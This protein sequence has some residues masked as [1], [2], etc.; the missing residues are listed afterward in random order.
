VK[1]SWDERKRSC[2]T[3]Q[4]CARHADWVS[5]DGDSLSCAEGE[6]SEEGNG[7]AFGETKDIKKDISYHYEVEADNV[8]DGN[9]QCLNARGEA[10]SVDYGNDSTLCQPMGAA[11]TMALLIKS[12]TAKT[13]TTLTITKP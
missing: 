6:E 8:H 3:C 4:G 9:Y 11:L 12:Q 7:L 5:T 2:S 13:I 10:H 1:S